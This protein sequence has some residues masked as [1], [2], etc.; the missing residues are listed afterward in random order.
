MTLSAPLAAL[1]TAIVFP[2]ALGSGL[3]P[4]PDPL[5]MAFLFLMVLLGTWGVLI[6]TKLWE[7]RIVSR[8]TR[9]LVQ[10]G[11]GLALGI[12]AFAL[13]EWGRMSP[14][15]VYEVPGRFLTI[16]EV[17]FNSTD[18]VGGLALAGY[19]GLVY[20]ASGWWKLTARDR[21]SR[22]RFWPV[23]KAVALAWLIGL[24]FPWLNP[25]GALVIGLIALVTQLV[26]PWDAQAAVVAVSQRECRVA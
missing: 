23:I 26:S 2:L 18:E 17:P 13:M 7:G 9:R 4:Q 6:S 21:S 12:C 24:A 25:W 22:F 19:F 16:A 14:A 20:A 15:P 1:G 8:G 11:I 10:L 5:Q 3:E